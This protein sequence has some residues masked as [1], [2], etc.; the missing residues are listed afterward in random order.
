MFA[1]S[2]ELGVIEKYGFLISLFTPEFVL[3]TGVALV[4]LVLITR[5]PK[6][7]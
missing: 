6:V 4:A 2:T 3:L 1:F 5:G 7:R